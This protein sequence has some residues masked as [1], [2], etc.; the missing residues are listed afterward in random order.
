MGFPTD[1]IY[2]LAADPRRP[3]AVER[4][5][6]AKGRPAH[7]AIP[8]IAASLEQ[9]ERVGRLPELGRRLAEAFWPGP[10]TLV[11]SARPSVSA[12]VRGGR[13]TVAVRVPDHAVARALAGAL[14]G[15]VTATSANRSGEPGARS[16]GAVVAAL[17][18][19]VQLV[20]DGGAAAAETPS[21]IVDVSQETPTLIREG[22]VP[23]DRVV[24]SCEGAVPRRVEARNGARPETGWPRREEGAYWAYATDEQRREGVRPPR[25]CCCEA[26]M[27]DTKIAGWRGDGRPRR[28][29]DSLTR[30]R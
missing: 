21:T 23:W 2:G 12:R 25:A 16:A 1:T 28:A 3:D 8:L 11:V 20:L 19:A 30:T 15:S 5:Y 13:A 24:A 9:V 26:R 29:R 18:P 22:A 10:L 14:G 17:G 4:L 27:P 7:L 6:E